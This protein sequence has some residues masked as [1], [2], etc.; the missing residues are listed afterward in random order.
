M[1]KTSNIESEKNVEK[2][3]E[4]LDSICI[5]DEEMAGT[6]ER[7]EIPSISLNDGLI[8]VASEHNINQ[9]VLYIK[10]NKFYTGCLFERICLYKD[11]LPPIT[12]TASA[13]KC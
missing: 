11:Q 1:K 5:Q 4:Y 6:K 13:G 7:K 10:I 12:Q 2:F 9:Q 3:S 8:H